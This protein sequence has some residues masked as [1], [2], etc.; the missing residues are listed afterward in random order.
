MMNVLQ[1]I[2]ESLWMADGTIVDFYGFAYPTRMLVVRLAGG[3]L[4]VW[5]PVRL[6]EQ[7]GVEIEALGDVAHL[8]SPNKLHHLYLAEWHRAFPRAL[9]WGPASTIRRCRQ[10]PFGP[11]L[12]DMPPPEWALDIEQAWFRGSFAMDEIVFFHRASRTAIFADLIE[13]FGDEF[14][15]AHWRWWQRRLARFDGITAHA[16]HAPLEWRLSFH[17]REPARAAREKVL[18]WRPERVVMA[19]GE[20]CRS[21]GT[22][23]IA[24]ALAWLGKSPSRRETA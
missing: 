2:G 16:P 24:R 9:L 14:L 21:G 11:P 6:T 18:G 22:D 19:H 7:L 23:Y 20:W 1:P 10:L 15:C 4:W 12:Q 5:S 13:A 8:V 3:G 17:N